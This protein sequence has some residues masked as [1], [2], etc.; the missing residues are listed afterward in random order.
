MKIIN[1]N[2]DFKNG[3]ENRTKTDKIVIH[4]RAGDGDVQSIHAQHKN[5]GFSGI[6]YHFYVRKSGQVYKGRPIA[7]VGAHAIG[8]NYDSIGVCFEGNFDVEDTM[9]PQQLKAGKE[10]VSYLKTLYPRAEIISHRDVQSTAC[11]GRYFPF[12]NIRE[13]VKEL[14]VEEAIE[15][16]QAKAG[17]EDETIDF[18]LFYKYGEE[19]SV[20]IAEAMI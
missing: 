12:E 17:L 14:T 2:Y 16:V 7:S 1:E 15:I 5:Q 3:L 9:P 18:L 20:K 13:G 4:H 6:G 10:L 8:A 11:P 19:L